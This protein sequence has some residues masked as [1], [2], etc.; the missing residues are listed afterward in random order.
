M[1]LTRET[2]LTGLP[3]VG[4]Q[5]AKKLEKLGLYTLGDVL[6]HLPQRYED[7]RESCGLRNAPADRPCCVTAMVAQPPRVSF[8]RRGLSLVKVKAVDGTAALNITFFNQDYIRETLRPGESYVFYGTV[9]RQGNLF[10]MTNPVFEREG[11]ARFTGLIMPVYPLTAGISNNLL[12]GLSRRA[13][14][15]CLDGLPEVLPAQV[16]KD[17]QLCQ[18][19]YARKNIHYPDSFEELAIARRRLVF[20]ELFVLT[21]GLARLKDRRSRG[22]GRPMAGEP[23]EFAALLPFTPTGAQRRAMEDIAADL[24]SGKAMNRLV[25]GDVG[26]GKTAVA[27]F[28]AWTAAKNGAQCALMAPTELLAEQHAKTLHALLSPVGMRVA[29]LTGAVKGKEKKALL[30]A[31]AAGEIDLLVGTHALFS[32][33]VEYRDLGL[34]I[35]DEQ[36]RFGVAQRAALAE[37]GWAVPPHVLIMSATPIPR[38]L[39]LIIYGDLD[40]SVMDELPPGRTPVDTLLVGED[41]RQRMYGFVRKQVAEGRQVYIVCPSVEENGCGWEDGPGMDLKA[42]TAYAKELR[43]KVFPDLRVG[44]V[45]GKLKSKEKEAARAAFAGGEMD[46]LV[47]TTVIEVGVDVPNASLMIVENAERFGLSQLHQLR[48]RVGRGRH[49]SWCVLVTSS[50]SETARERLKALSATNDGFQIAEEDLRLRGPGDFFGKRQ[51]GLP[52]LKVADFA[53]DMELLREARAAAEKLIAGDPELKKPAHRLLKYRVR[54][55]FEENRELF[56]NV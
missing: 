34:V 21:C 35:A 33:G 26:A 45:H 25:Q 41:K 2:P 53:A 50:R 52:Q 49:Q 5:R 14:D 7:R 40:V 24:R 17:H 23:G 8:V 56:R 20:E 11:A 38:T 43:E 30:A 39:A 46:V 16:R 18:T 1:P 32:E 48:G 19:R 51:H 54:E 13:V 55:L 4:P 27:A 29:L 31:L 47:S 3:G 9:E 36:H 22:S 12:A 42:V 37:K 6:E 15:A 28:G 44:F 10:F